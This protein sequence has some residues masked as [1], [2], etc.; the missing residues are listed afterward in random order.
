LQ[1][2][3]SRLGAD[4]AIFDDTVLAAQP[5]VT[6]STRVQGLTGLPSVAEAAALAASDDGELLLPRQVVAA[7]GGQYVTVA[8][9]QL[10]DAALRGLAVGRG[11]A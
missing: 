11:S 4:F 5:V 3:A 7:G 2:W 10:N 6:R 1:L 9:A 8:I